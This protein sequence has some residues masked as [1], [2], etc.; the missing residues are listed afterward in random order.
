[1]LAARR[2]SMASP[3]PLSPSSLPRPHSSTGHHNYGQLRTRLSSDAASVAAAALNDVPETRNVKVVLR[4]RPSNPDDASIP[5]RY[6]SV[7][8]HPTSETEI[9]VDVDPATLAGHAGTVGSSRKHPTFTF[10]NVL[11]EDSVQ[12]DLYDATAG[13]NV[14]EFMKGH[15]VTFLAYGQTSSGKSYSMGTTGEDTDYSGT[16]FTPRTGLIPRTVQTILERAEESKQQAGPGASWEARISFLELY[17]EEIID[18]LSGTG[19]SISIREERDGRIVWSGV[20]EAKVKSLA[21]V[22]QLL[23]EG[24]ARR[25]TSETNMNSSSSRSHAIFSLTL[26]QKRIAGPMSSAVASSRSE[27]PTR[28]LRRPSSMM[29]ISS[30]G[31]AR[32]P[33]PTSGRGGGPP[34]SFGRMT[35]SRPTSVIGTPTGADDY[36]IVTSKFNMVDLAGS[37]RLKRTAAQGDRMKEGISINS[38]LLALGNVISTLC[39]PVKARGHIPYRDSKLTRML[40]DSIG[41]NALTTM[42]A[43]VSPIEANIGETL[44]TIKYASRARNIR[45]QTKVNAVEAGWDD[46]EHLQTT[47]LK[48]RKQI[49]MLES[50]SKGS[51]SEGNSKHSEKLIQRLAELQR[52][53]T[54]LYDRYLAKC[55]DNM[56]LGSELR[57]R[58]PGDGDALSKFN[59]TVEPV[60]LEYE[61]VVSALNQ[62]LDELRGEIVIINDLSEEHNRQ[63]EEARDRQLQSESY[64]T[65]LR[66]RLTKL[67]ERNSSS[68]AYIQDLEAKLKMYA[69]KED[70]HADAVAELK[71]DISKLRENNA[72][73]VSNAQELEAKLSRSE[74]ASSKLVAQVEKQEEDAQVRESAYREL[75]AHIVRLEAQSLE[76][77]KRLLGELS[78]RDDKILELEEELEKQRLDGSRENKLLEAVNAEKAAQQ[79]LRI[80]LAS[81]QKSASGVVTPP[82][83]GSTPAGSVIKKS[84]ASSNGGEGEPIGE[85]EQLRA[86]FE[87]LA[88]EHAKSESHIADLTS[89]LSEAKLVQ[90]EMEDTMPLSPSSPI[91]DHD[92]HS[93]DELEEVATPV[94]DLPTP[95]RSA[96]GSSPTKR[97]TSSASMRRSSLP[98]LN[99]GVAVKMGFRGG[100]GFSDSTRIRPQSLSQEL[101]SAQSSVSSPRATW[102]DPNTNKLLLSSPSMVPKPSSKS[103]QSLE[104][105][106]RFVHGIVDERDEELRDREAYIRQ[107]EEQ[108]ELSKTHDILSR[109]NR[110]NPIDVTTSEI[111][112]IDTEVVELPRTPETPGIQLQPSD[113][114]LP[115][116]PAPMTPF[117]SLKV[118]AGDQDGDDEGLKPPPDDGENG[119]LSPRS[120][121]RFSQLA[122]SLSR[123]ESKEGCNEQDMIQELMREM[124]EKEASQRRII[125]QQFIQIADLQKSNNKLKE[126]LIEVEPQLSS[127]QKLRS[128]RDL[129]TA[130]KAAA[131]SPSPSPVPSPSRSIHSLAS[132]AALDRLQ[133]EHSEDLQSIITGHSQTIKVI[134]REHQ[135]EIAKLQAIIEKNEAVIEEWAAK[136]EGLKLEHHGAQTAQRLDQEAK[137]AA[138]QK[139]LDWL[140]ADHAEILASLKDAH[141]RALEDLQSEQDLIAQEMESS[142][143]SSE[144]QRRQLKMKADQALFELSR[145]RDEHSLQ[146]NGDAKQISE[147]TKA[148]AQLEKVK[149]ELEHANAELKG[150]CADLKHQTGDKRAT[151]LEQRFSRKLVPPPQVPPPTTPLPPLPRSS[152]GHGTRLGSD[153]ASITP[154]MPQIGETVGQSRRQSESSAGHSDGSG[155]GGSQAALYGALAER[156]G[157]RDALV[158]DKERIKEIERELQGEKVKIK[159]LTVDLREAQKQANTIRSHLD[160]ARQENK[161]S[162][163]S[164][165]EHTSELEA[166]REQMAKLAEQ[167]RNHRDSLQA[168]QAQVA[169]LKLQLERAVETKVQKRGFMCF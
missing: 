49:S 48:L 127:I 74:A 28:Q 35:P 110:A 63:L 121:K 17:N 43:C 95:A 140:K 62:Q 123:L 160:E 137:E 139:K 65:E 119:A 152:S 54:E 53:H 69:D 38:G 111:E 75:E 61:K 131:T 67:T 40:Q 11:G 156:D 5:A 1:M 120:V 70:S 146:Q 25:K 129:L 34:S 14:D 136:V 81:M 142:L 22:M 78:D 117:K 57:N 132:S 30:A 31:S 52:E 36:I 107:L 99:N 71:K 153:G 83:E 115:P 27:T 126:E 55:S 150:Q 145:V 105:E 148:N 130:E 37:E 76:D 39:D 162:A 51:A 2:Q 167:E 92:S 98:L 15:N 21:E 109:K 47:V 151:E 113:F 102:R 8:V 134:Q 96:P 169:S 64:V 16:N 157:L 26:V 42:I 58:G 44:N 85:L 41:G 104:A 164:C 66:S 60:I 89:Q 33:T 13:E 10:D 147:L 79:E 80:R 155:E 77:S 18:L 100:R 161:R 143:S 97:R 87:K 168:S 12:T 128:E 50:D 135:D 3:G 19:I 114:P 9:R 32:S 56:R 88:A 59:E 144:E 86:A 116:S 68:E 82:S 154:S 108:L 138:H 73:S 20:R 46:V 4:V 29:G 118:E 149:T 7:L 112:S 24:S 23:Q 94:D 125:E 159:N 103:V 124:A 165:R 133:E 101:S 141:A 122:E 84:A 91:I 163:L 6:R 93:D 72:S 158:K 166:R 90:G 45:N 106:L